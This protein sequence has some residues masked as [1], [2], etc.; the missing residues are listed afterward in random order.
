MTS[1]SY[2]EGGLLL[3]LELGQICGEAGALTNDFLCFPF[4]F[5]LASEHS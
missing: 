2:L 4:F 5:L 1:F 3:A